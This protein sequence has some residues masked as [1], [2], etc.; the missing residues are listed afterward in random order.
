MATRE[1]DIVS[2]IKEHIERFGTTVS[3]TMWER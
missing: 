3:V 1:Q 2:V